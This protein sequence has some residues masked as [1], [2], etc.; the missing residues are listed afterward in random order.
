M[1][2]ALKMADNRCSV[3]NDAA[4]F[5]EAVFAAFYTYQRYANIA[6]IELYSLEP[7]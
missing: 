5:L 3:D 7:L 1:N 6:S 4:L 2:N